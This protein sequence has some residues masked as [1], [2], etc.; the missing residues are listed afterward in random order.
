MISSEVADEIAVIT[1]A[2]PPVNALSRRWADAFHKVLDALNG[3][4]DW[5]VLIIR[6]SQRVFS[7]GG[8]VKEF[9]QR[10]EDPEAGNLLAEEAAYYQGLFLR[11][12]SLPQISVAEIR[13]VAAG[14]GFELAL[15]CDLRIAAESARVGL[16]EVGLGLLPS[17]GGMQRMTRLCGR[18]VAMRL[19]GGAEMVSG[20]QAH[21]LGLVEWVV[22]DS[23]FDR[24]VA[25][26]TTRLVG[27]PR[28]ALRAAK[29]CIGA[30]LD[31]NRDGYA[32]AAKAPRFLMNSPETRAKITAFLRKSSKG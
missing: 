24:D 1:L 3:R 32:E 15:A 9:A 5:R 19:V 18:G 2:H 26:I 7:A 21:D 10:L 23:E 8:D 28:E 29:S 13:G 4:D 31:P 22:S 11:I 20:R 25:E 6:S 12:E 14:G 30:A 27:Q 17:A 16:P